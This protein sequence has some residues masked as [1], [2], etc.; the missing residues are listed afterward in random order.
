MFKLA[1]LVLA[2][3]FGA[4]F[5][6]CA[7]KKKADCAKLDR[8][9]CT[10]AGHCT[11]VKT[12]GRKPSKVYLCRPARGKC[13]KN[14]RQADIMGGP[15]Y[16]SK[17][18]RKE[19]ERVVAGKRRCTGRPGC[20]VRPGSCYCQCKGYGSTKVPDKNAPIC[21]CACAGG[22]PPACVAKQ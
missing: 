5:G 3:G 1:C 17:D 13:E 18:W 9:A 15:G 8:F 6:G 16:A 11:L 10:R 2:A 7:A 19:K 14:F 22:P 12:G 21:N 4:N 20:V